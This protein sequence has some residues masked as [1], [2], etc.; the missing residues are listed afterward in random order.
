MHL[1]VP[2]FGRH[3]AKQY[4]G[5][6][7]FVGAISSVTNGLNW[8][9]SGRLAGDKL[10]YVD[11]SSDNTST[12]SV[13][14]SGFSLI[15]TSQTVSTSF[16]VQ[17]LNISHKTS[18]GTEG[19]V[20]GMNNG[21]NRKWGLV[22]RPHGGVFAAP[23]NISA[24]TNTSGNT[25]ATHTITA[26]GRK[27]VVAITCTMSDD[28]NEAPPSTPAPVYDSDQLSDIFKHLTVW[29][30]NYAPVSLSISG[31]TGGIRKSFYI[32]LT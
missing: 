20:T 30:M 4:P 15:G 29:I 9:S 22:L 24:N 21:D 13:T 18:D 14:P 2:R 5:A 32:P 23:A 25:I 1:I 28:G 31:A 11:A 6:W 27:P 26:A 3:R 12:T 10:V 17:R 19:N 7:S 16:A 8:S